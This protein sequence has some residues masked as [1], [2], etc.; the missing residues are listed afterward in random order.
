[1]G[2]AY[3]HAKQV[4]VENFRHSIGEMPI[5][6]RIVLDHIDKYGYEPMKGLIGV[7]YSD[8]EVEFDDLSR[9]ASMFVEGDRMAFEDMPFEGFSYLGLKEKGGALMAQATRAENRIYGYKVG[10]SSRRVTMQ[11]Y[12]QDRV[13]PGFVDSLLSVIRDVDLKDPAEEPRLF[14]KYTLIKSDFVGGACHFCKHTDSRVVNVKGVDGFNY[15]YKCNACKKIFRTK[16]GALFHH[17]GVPLMKLLS[18]IPLALDPNGVSS[19]DMAAT[20]DIGHS[21]AWMIRRVIRNNS[22]MGHVWPHE[23]VNNMNGVKNHKTRIHVFKSLEDL[24]RLTKK[25]RS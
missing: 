24:R 4:E 17:S 16:S 1:M 25:S 10:A 11:T 21:T 5:E 20:L 3:L 12:G 6:D 14:L 2:A 13:A 18:A 7:D 9:S 15:V 23:K 19:H 8:I 22:L